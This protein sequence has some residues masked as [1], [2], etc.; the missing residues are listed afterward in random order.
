MSHICPTTGEL[1]LWPIISWRASETVSHQFETSLTVYE[2]EKSKLD[3]SA[4]TASLALQ[5]RID[6][7]TLLAHSLPNHLDHVRSR[8]MGG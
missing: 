1:E 4:Y 7:I 2:C 5:H 3:P 6:L 8:L